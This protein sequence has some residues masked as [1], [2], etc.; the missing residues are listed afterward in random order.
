MSACGPSLGDGT[1]RGG[2]GGGGGTASAATGIVS[3]SSAGTVAAD[4]TTEPMGS[5][6]TSVEPP[7]ASCPDTAPVGAPDLPE[8]CGPLWLVD[9]EGNP[10]EGQ[11]SGFAA[12]PAADGESS[13]VRRIAPVACPMLLGDECLCDADCPSG[14]A[15]VCANQL[16]VLWNFSGG[17]NNRCVLSDCAEAGDCAGEPC[18]V[19]DG[20][21]GG[22]PF[23]SAIRCSGPSDDC[24]VD[25]DCRGMG[26]QCEYDGGQEL[27]TCSPGAI[28]E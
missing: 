26:G 4:T 10:L 11:F 9:G 18:R 24:E 28:C 27:F 2:D 5:S 13:V 14:T 16:T 8:G 25:A 20:S 1:D 3:V 22:I 15:C 12:C 17:A 19:D 23:L 7:G 6:T 21:C